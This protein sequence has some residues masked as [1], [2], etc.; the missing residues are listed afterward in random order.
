M[1]GGVIIVSLEV[2]LH[3]GFRGRLLYVPAVVLAQTHRELDLRYCTRDQHDHTTTRN[4]NERY[5]FGKEGEEK[6]ILLPLD[7]CTV[8][9]HNQYVPYLFLTLSHSFTSDVVRRIKR[10]KNNTVRRRKDPSNL[11]L[12][13]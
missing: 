12:A 10:T 3:E 9:T 7:Y 2:L 11:Q 13:H 8:I 6:M 5:S 4:N 1:V